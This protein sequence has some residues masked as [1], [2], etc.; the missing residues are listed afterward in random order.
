MPQRPDYIMLPKTAS[1]QTVCGCDAAI[2]EI[3]RRCGMEPGT[4][5]LIALIE[6]AL[7]VENAFEIAT[8]SPRVR[9]LFLGAEDLSADL[10]CSR[11]KEGLEILYARTRLVT[12]AHAAGIDVYDTPFTD[13]ND[14]EGIEADSRLARSLGFTGKAAISPRHLEAINRCF[15]PSQ[16]E[17]DYAREVLAAIEDAKRC[18]KGAVALRGKMIDAPIAARARQTLAAAEE[19][20]AEGGTLQ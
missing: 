6:T 12:A 19:I 14:D 7:G 11:T 1:R 18:G 4:I 2:G 9:A 13:V 3:E 15:S 20:L 8:A 5:G 17:T 10:H 16:A